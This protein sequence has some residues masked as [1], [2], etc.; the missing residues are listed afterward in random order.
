MYWKYQLL[1][2]TLIA[3]QSVSKTKIVLAIPGTEKGKTP[4]YKTFAYCS[5]IFLPMIKDMLAQVIH[6]YLHTYVKKFSL[7]TFTHRVKTT[8]TINFFIL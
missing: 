5:I 1:T 4:D 3:S 2:L 7:G 8:T 6:T